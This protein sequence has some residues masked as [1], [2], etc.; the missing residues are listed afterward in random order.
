VSL[1]WPALRTTAFKS[2]TSLSTDTKIFMGIVAPLTRQRNM[3]T[4]SSD[5]AGSIV[6]VWKISEFKTSCTS[7]LLYSCLGVVV[8]VRVGM[9]SETTRAVT[10]FSHMQSKGASG[11][12]CRTGVGGGSS[13]SL[14]KF[15]QTK[16]GGVAVNFPL[17]C[18]ILMCYTQST[19]TFL[20]HD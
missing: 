17:G 6:G 1:F 13:M 8:H 3:R 14:K 11:F 18:S 7:C 2:S 5:I 15:T 4:V 20:T 19:D 10:F 9:A 16:T 12:G